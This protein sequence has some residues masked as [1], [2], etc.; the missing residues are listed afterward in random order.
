MS[1]TKTDNMQ[2]ATYDKGSHALEAS[3]RRQLMTE[4]GV[5]FQ[6]LVVR[7]VNDGVC[8]QGVVEVDDEGFD[9]TKLALKIMDVNV[10][11]NELLVRRPR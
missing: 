8:L 10:V 11:R 5:D 7:R 6:S 2:A 4:E 1:Q 3:V 9:A